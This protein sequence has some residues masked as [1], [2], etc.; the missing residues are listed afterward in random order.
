MTNGRYAGTERKQRLVVDKKKSKNEG[1]WSLE[2]L[3]FYKL[4]T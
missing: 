1:E 4:Y 2:L 3:K